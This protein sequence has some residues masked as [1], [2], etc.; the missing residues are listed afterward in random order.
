MGDMELLEAVYLDPRVSR[1]IES[2]RKAVNW[3]NAEEVLG[4]GL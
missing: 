4:A 2:L 1:N 3:Q